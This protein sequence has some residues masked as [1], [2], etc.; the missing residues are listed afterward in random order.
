M[1]SAAAD[2][3]LNTRRS[4]LYTRLF[5]P[6][7][8]LTRARDQPFP[9]ASTR[10]PPYSPHSVSC[11]ID[12]VPQISPSLHSLTHYYYQVLLVLLT[13]RHIITYLFIYTCTDQ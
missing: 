4:S 11:H 3:G 9:A 5:S 13:N 7:H 2:S 10:R 12:I 1:G 6:S 8:S